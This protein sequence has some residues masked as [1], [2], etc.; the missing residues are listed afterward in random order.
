MK[1]LCV[2]AACCL[3]SVGMMAQSENIGFGFRAGASY[4]K[5]NGPSEIGPDGSDLE[6][7]S[8]TSG[9]HIG[10]AV[11]YK[12]SDLMGMRAEFVYS[13]RGS[14]ND[15]NG[16]S[17]YV[18]GRYDVLNQTIRGT[19]NQTLKVTNAYIDIPILFYYR[20]GKLELSGGFNSS[21]LLASTAGGS[22]DFNG[23]SSIGTPVDPFEVGLEHN[24][25]SDEA[26]EASSDLQY[27]DVDGFPY[28]VPTRTGAYYEFLEKD[29]DNFKTF[30]FG[31]VACAAF[32]INEGLYISARYIHGLTD[33]DRNEY[34]VSLQLAP[35]ADGTGVPRA[36]KNTIQA[37][38]FSVGF[39]F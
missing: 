12:Y 26:M 21:I 35:N 4:S 5:F 25:K 23:V 29:K 33:V 11:N 19:R 10:A 28:A 30:D 6:S 7:F 36:D 3:M 13:Q 31:L 39:S 17:Y 15:Y 20:I 22:T 37:W 2:F 1:Y 32:Y 8:N 18:L 9:F 27:V 24:Y 34:D 38:Q 14:I 16:P